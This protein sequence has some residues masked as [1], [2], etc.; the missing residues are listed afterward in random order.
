MYDEVSAMILYFSGTGNSLAVAKKI[1]ERTGDKA[2]HITELMNRQ[3]HRIQ[4]KV[5][6]F[7][8]PVYFEDVPQPMEW[9]VDYMQFKPSA[10]FYS[11]ATC[12]STSGQSFYT[13]QKALARKGCHLFYARKIKMVANSSAARRSHIKYAMDKLITAN[14]QI[15]AI[16]DDINNRKVDTSQIKGHWYMGLLRVGF[17]RRLSKKLFTIRCDS[18]LCVH[19]GTCERVCPMHNIRIENGTVSVGDN[20]ACCLACAHWCPQQ[21]IT[22]RNR[23]IL[24]EDQYHH[25]DVTLKDMLLR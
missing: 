5:I 23:H 21:A 7:V 14:E 3:C 12:G 2:I 24:L 8:F 10:Y 6:G 17:F 19:C 4:D 18:A 25:P 13:L 22:I 9:F 15:D 1:A 20:C 11:I 16:C